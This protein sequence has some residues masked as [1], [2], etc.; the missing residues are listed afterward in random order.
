M[1]LFAYKGSESNFGDELNH[2][3]WDR[4]L[5][6]FFNDDE[7]ELFLGIG[8]VLYDSHP[9]KSKKIVFGA[10]YAGYSNLPVID[11]S[12]DFYFV[13]GKETAKQ[14][15][16][17]ENLAI[18]DSGILIRSVIKDQAR[19][20]KYKSSYIPHFESAIVGSWEK[21]CE[22]SGVNFID[23]RWSVDRV[24]EEILA[25]EVVISEAMHGVIIADS[26]RVPW[27][28]VRPFDPNHRK[29]WQDWASVLDVDICFHSI[30]ASN[31]MEFICGLCWSK[32]RAIYAIR[33]RHLKL[34]KMGLSFPFANAVRKLSAL[35]LHNGQLSDEIKLQSAHSKME[36]LLVKLKSDYKDQGL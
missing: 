2:W 21:I 3:L 14:L 13:R 26:L 1:K 36:E 10:G 29:K 12:W 17:S 9:E 8:S 33:K 31:I 5:P 30:G 27:I 32:R 15:N 20:K 35:S 24:L 4:L 16:L 6:G 23:P 11:N 25:S 19:V 34:R 7:D 22:K 18:G 28:A